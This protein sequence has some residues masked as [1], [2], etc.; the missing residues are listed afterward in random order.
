MKLVSAEIYPT[1]SNKTNTFATFRKKNGKIS[2]ISFY[3]SVSSDT[4]S[5]KNALL[6][7]SCPSSETNIEL[8]F[9]PKRLK[10]DSLRLYLKSKC[11]KSFPSRSFIFHPCPHANT[12]DEK[13]YTAISILA[14]SYDELYEPKVFTASELALV[15]ISKTLY[16]DKLVLHAYANQ[17][18]LIIS[19]SKGESLLYI[20]STQIE[21]DDNEALADDLTLTVTHLIRN[22]GIKP[23]LILFSGTFSVN[24]ELWN[25]AEMGCSV[26]VA[27]PEG[28]IENCSFED[29][30][31]I[32][33]PLGST[34]N[35][36]KYD[37]TPEKQLKQRAF[38]NI[39][40]T[41]NVILFCALGFLTIHNTTLLNRYKEKADSLFENTLALREDRKSTAEL[42]G[43]SNL[44]EYLLYY[45]DLLAVRNENPLRKI[46]DIEPLINHIGFERFAISRGEPIAVDVSKEFGTLTSLTD[47]EEEVK[48]EV[49]RLESKGYTIQNESKYNYDDLKA[50]I[51]LTL[52]GKSI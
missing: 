28:I 25:M 35:G 34:L 30:H 14:S 12:T 3:N 15:G 44:Y 51:K 21:T 48:S 9:A 36:D 5:N 27:A 29:F 22:K 46:K 42:I 18:K 17:D 10:G 39:T 31:K 33:I 52:R 2:L 45:L 24:S 19:V 6:I 20:R 41:L 1:N 49:L 50:D 37:F 16:P 11:T 8:I 13:A 47:F 43:K 23:E 40:L 38:S 4:P 26:A 32:I 7:V